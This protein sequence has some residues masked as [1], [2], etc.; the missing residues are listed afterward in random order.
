MISVTVVSSPQTTVSVNSVLEMKFP[1][2]QARASVTFVV[3]VSRQIRSTQT[4]NYVRPVHSL[5]PKVRARCVPTDRSPAH[6]VHAS[7]DNVQLDMDQM[8]YTPF[9]LLA[10]LEHSHR[11]VLRAKHVCRVI[12]PLDLAPV[13][14]ALVQ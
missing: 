14:A 5:P 6:P 4:V 1:E 12:S 11:T 13:N 8:L 10:P 7:A 9:V 2:I 3:A